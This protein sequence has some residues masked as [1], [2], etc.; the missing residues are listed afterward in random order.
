MRGCG[1]PTR[2]VWETI[3]GYICSCLTND[4]TRHLSPLLFFFTVLCNFPK[5]LT[6]G[7]KIVST[8]S[9]HCRG[10]QIR[11]I[12]T[13]PQP[14]YAI[15]VVKTLLQEELRMRI[16]LLPG[17]EIVHEFM[18]VFIKQINLFSCLVSCCVFHAIQNLFNEGCCRSRSRPNH[19]LEW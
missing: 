14:W 15:L 9:K 5:P 1:P 17:R 10:F 16:F 2:T 11:D 18:Y 4:A 13:I 19:A 3:F 8:G 6:L 7:T 12:G